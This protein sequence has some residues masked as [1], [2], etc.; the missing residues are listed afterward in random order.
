MNERTIQFLQMF[1][2]TLLSCRL[3]DHERLNAGLLEYIEKLRGIAPDG[4]TRSNVLGWQS[5]NLDYD[6]PSVAEFA[7][8]VLERA[9]EYGLAHSWN[10]PSH[11]QLIMREIWANVSGKHAYNNVHNHPNSLL[12][13]VYYVKA[14]RNCGD[15][16]IADPRKQAWVMQPEFVERNQ[17]NSSVHTIPPEVGKLII[18]PSWLDH[19]VNPN[20]SDTDRISMSFNINLMHEQMVGNGG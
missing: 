20:L 13:G 7:T 3:P 8:L 16:L 14:E 1:P 5:G 19:G 2:T 12:S 10:F 18:F 15:L 17:M 9:R 6:V 11:M 4:R